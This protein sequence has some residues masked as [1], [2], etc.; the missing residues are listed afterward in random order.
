MMKVIIEIEEQDD[1]QKVEHFLKSFEIT[2]VQVDYLQRRQKLQ[3][4]FDYLDKTTV[5]V[6]KIDI[7]EEE[8]AALVKE[9]ADKLT[10]LRSALIAGENSG[11]V[12]NY[13]LD[14]LLA[15]LDA[16]ELA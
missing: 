15:E 6:K 2:K 3:N 8:T 5:S 14:N 11:V 7:L 12:E 9:Q 4:F 1:M 10:V 16:E 13:S